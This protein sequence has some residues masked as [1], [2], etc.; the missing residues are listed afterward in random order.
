VQAAQP[1]DTI[2]LEPGEYPE[3]VVLPDGVALVARVPG[4]VTLRAAAGQ[5]DWVGITATGALGNHISGIRISGETEAP[6]AIGLKLAG[7]DLVVDDVTIGGAVGVGVDIQNDGTIVVRAS[8]FDGLAGTSM[9]IGSR[10]RPTIRQNVFTRGTGGQRTALSVAEGS[11][12][13]LLANV[14]VNYAEAEVLAAEPPARPA[15][16]AAAVKALLRE[17]Y[18]VRASRPSPPA[19]RSPLAAPRS[20]ILD[21]GSPTPDP[22]SPIPDPRSPA[23][24]PRAQPRGTSHV[25]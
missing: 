24:G 9:K 5:P 3:A 19:A 23:P 2:Q 18:L 20:P 10:A 16:A 6:M 13:E 8:R 15:A 25:R 1:K 21:P 17:N 14:F 7:H 22:R 4:T 11:T 12:P